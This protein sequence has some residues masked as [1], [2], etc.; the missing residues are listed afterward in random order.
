M[1][2]AKEQA[3]ISQTTTPNTWW[4]LLQIQLL[5]YLMEKA[6]AHRYLARQLPMPDG[7]WSYTLSSPLADGDHKFTIEASKTAANGEEL[8]LQACRR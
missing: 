7:N 1:I 5:A 3:Y 8:K 2:V 4:Q 6:R